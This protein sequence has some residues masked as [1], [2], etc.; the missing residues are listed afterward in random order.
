M[1]PDSKKRCQQCNAW[2]ERK[3]RRSRTQHHN[4]LHPRLHGNGSPA[5]GNPTMSI[6]LKNGTT[7]KEN[8]GQPVWKVEYYLF[9]VQ[10]NVQRQF[11]F[12]N[13]FFGNRWQQ[14][15]FTDGECRSI[16]HYTSYLRTKDC[17]NNGYVTNMLEHITMINIDT[18]VHMISHNTQTWA[19]EYRSLIH[20]VSH[21]GSRSSSARHSIHAWS[22]VRCVCVG[23]SLH[24]SPLLLFSVAPLPA[25]PDALLRC[26]QEVHVSEPA[27]L[28]LGDRGQ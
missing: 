17:T 5:G 27:Q 7:T 26:P 1:N 10:L 19:P 3:T 4:L 15:T 14:S 8:M 21:R 22:S 2:S 18:G 24:L 16:M 13:F 6:H 28:P 25:L 11:E 9:V 12:E 20:T 23:C